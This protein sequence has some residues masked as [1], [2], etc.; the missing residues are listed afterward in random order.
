MPRDNNYDGGW[1]GHLDLQCLNNNQLWAGGSNGFLELSTNG[2]GTPLPKAYF[3]IDT[4]NVYNTSIVKLV[5]ASKTTYQ[6]QWFKNDVL[7]STSYHTTYT[8]NFFHPLDTIKLVVSN[9][10]NTDTLIRYQYADV[11]P[12]IPVITSFTPTAG[13]AG[14]SVSITGS[15]FNGTTAVSFGGTPASSFTV[16]SATSI[17]AIVAGG[18]SGSVAVTNQYGT[19]TLAGFN[20]I[21]FPAPVITSFS[22]TFG[23]AGTT[24][25]ITGSYFDPVAANNIVYFGAA[26]AV[27]SAASATQL[28][29]QVPTGATFKP[30]TVLNTSSHFMGYSVKPFVVTFPGGGGAFTSSSF[31]RIPINTPSGG[32]PNIENGDFDNDGKPD[33]VIGNN[34]SNGGQQISVYRNTSTPAVVSFVPAGTYLNLGEDRT[35]RYIR[36]GDI[37][38]DGKL[39]IV[40]SRDSNYNGIGIITVF[41]NTSTVGNISFA[42]YLN[43]PSGNSQNDLAI[44]DMDGDGRSD[45]ISSTGDPSRFVILRN[46]STVGNIAF[47][48]KTS[49]GTGGALASPLMML[50]MMINP[51]LLSRDGIRIPSPFIKIPVQWARCNWP[52]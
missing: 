44:R 1:F 8:A 48:P 28:V 16:N 11:L 9:G 30:I 35:I 3:S 5:N 33:I 18:S 19:G 34:S 41:R 51:M 14:T 38:G 10:T 37:D 46:I 2:G 50:T 22:P 32:W 17:T 13:V 7:I 52:L 49:F 27:V 4:N 36:T 43:F 29:V 23:Q 24:V 12:P 20:Y 47:A 39:D 40:V 6:Y 42:A 25:T 45:V 31:E 21:S 26:R 15:N